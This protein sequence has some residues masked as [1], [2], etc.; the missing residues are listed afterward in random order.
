MGKNSGPDQP[1]KI[2][3]IGFSYYRITCRNGWKWW[4]FRRLSQRM[5]R[6][7]WADKGCGGRVA[8]PWRSE[9]H[10]ALRCS[11]SSQ[12]W[13]K[14][15]ARQSVLPDVPQRCIGGINAFAP[16]AGAPNQAFCGKI[17][18]T[19]VSCRSRPRGQSSRFRREYPPMSAS[20]RRAGRQSSRPCIPFWTGYQNIYLIF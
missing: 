11:R 1:F 14:H 17:R 8:N 20:T 4:N 5:C 2:F 9:T 12:G 6:K 16:D 18:Q 13:G 3:R 7:Q 19:T 15:L 10:P